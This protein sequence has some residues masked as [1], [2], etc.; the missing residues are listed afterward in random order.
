MWAAPSEE[1]SLARIDLHADESAGAKLRRAPQCS[2]HL[3]KDQFVQVWR[4]ENNFLKVSRVNV[5]TVP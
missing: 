2:G 4:S 1:R 5:T 3:R